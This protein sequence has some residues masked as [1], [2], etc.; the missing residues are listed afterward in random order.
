MRRRAAY[1]ASCPPVRVCPQVSCPNPQTAVR[2]MYRALQ[3]RH[4]RSHKLNDYSSRRVQALLRRS[5]QQAALL[6]CTHRR[7][8]LSCH[9][10][11]APCLVPRMAPG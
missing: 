1:P 7:L 2:Y 8:V 3:Y 10:P 4:T 6:L 11:S 9:R 5:V